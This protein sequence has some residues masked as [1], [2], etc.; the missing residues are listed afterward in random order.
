VYAVAFNAAGLVAIGVADRG[1]QTIELWDMPAVPKGAGPNTK[2]DS[3]SKPA[4]SK[5]AESKPAES[6]PAESKPAE[7]KPAETLYLHALQLGQVGKLNDDQTDIQF[8][9]MLLVDRVLSENEVLIRDRSTV[10]VPRSKNFGKATGPGHK[11][12]IQMPTKGLVDNAQ[13]RTKDTVFEVFDT[14]QVGTAT[15]FVLRPRQDSNTHK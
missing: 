13:F 15:Y 5:P 1:L 8:T 9:Y 10:N 7:S 11:A 14:R 4:E 12:I 6:K 2:R 3:K